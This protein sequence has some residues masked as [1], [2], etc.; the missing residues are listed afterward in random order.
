MDRCRSTPVFQPLLSALSS[1]MW[2]GVAYY[3]SSAYLQH[4]VPSY[5]T[6]AKFADWVKRV[7]LCRA[8][9]ALCSNS[10]SLGLGLIAHL[11]TRL[12]FCI[13]KCSGSLSA[14][15]GIKIGIG[16]ELELGLQLELRNSICSRNN[17]VNARARNAMQLVLA[18]GVSMTYLGRYS[19]C[20]P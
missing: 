5:R 15:G 19:Y 1:F 16:I 13:G 6:K 4:H 18:N 2:P 8:L 3:I 11:G 20:P 7:L 9:E 10:V 14:R 12:F 17:S